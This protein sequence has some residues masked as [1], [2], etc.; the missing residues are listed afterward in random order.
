MGIQDGSGNLLTS[1]FGFRDLLLGLLLHV[2]DNSDQAWSVLQTKIFG[3]YQAC[4]RDPSLNI[5][6]LV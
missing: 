3:L 2:V 4:R 1:G 5:E 6:R